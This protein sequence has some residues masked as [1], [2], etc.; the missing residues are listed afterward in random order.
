MYCI[1]LPLIKPRHSSDVWN[2][3]CPN[4]IPVAETFFWLFFFGEEGGEGGSRHRRPE[5]RML[6]THFHASC[7]RNME[8]YAGV[9]ELVYTGTKYRYMEVEGFP[10]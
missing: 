10:L 5:Q 3:V 9:T 4:G 8:P 6:K 2:V 1:A 7:L